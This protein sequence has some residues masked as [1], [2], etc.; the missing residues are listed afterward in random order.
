ERLAEMQRILR[1]SSAQRRQW[2]RQ[3]AAERSVASR[4]SRDVPAV[5]NDN[6]RA[7]EPVPATE[8]IT[9]KQSRIA[10]WKWRLYNAVVPQAVR[11]WFPESLFGIRPPA[12]DLYVRSDIKEATE[13]GPDET[14]LLD[15]SSDASSS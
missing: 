12:T 3:E 14:E 11:R 4:R 7:L 15:R 1:G 13:H 10:R 5:A 2:R 8:L 9:F 6:V